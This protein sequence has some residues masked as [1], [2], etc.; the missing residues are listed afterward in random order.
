MWKASG[1]ELFPM[2]KVIK[3]LAGAGNLPSGQIAA[4]FPIACLHT[5]GVF[6][7]A[8]GSVFDSQSSVSI[9]PGWVELDSPLESDDR[10]DMI[11]QRGVGEAEVEVD[12]SIFGG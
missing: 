12:Q 10:L 11:A 7:A 5:S 8:E 6:L 3:H 4:Q 1:R 2:S 9:R